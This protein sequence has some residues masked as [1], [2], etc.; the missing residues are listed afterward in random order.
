MT[1]WY[2]RIVL[3]AALVAAVIGTYAVAYRSAMAAYEGRPVSMVQSLQVVVEALTTAGFGGHAPWSSDVVNALVMAMN[4]TGVLLFFLAVPAFVVPLFRNVF[5]ASLPTETDR[6]G[7]V[8]V[9]TCTPRGEALHD[10]L[11]RR[12]RTCVFI[13]PDRET[14]L[15]IQ[16]DGYEVIVGDPELTHVL[17]RANVTEAAGV[18]ADA[19]DDVNAS[20]ALSV[21]ELASDVRVV[22]LIEDADL[23]EYHRLAGADAVLSPRQLI[24]ASLAR[25]VPTL[26]TS[27]AGGASEIEGHVE[28]AELS[29]EP[30]SPLGGRLVR[31]SRL[32]E[33]FGFHAVG[34]WTDG[35]FVSPVG[36]DT[37]LRA[38]MRLL[39]VGPP[40]GVS[41]LRE[42]TASAVR[43]F[44][45]R[46]VVIA[47][48][49]RAGHAAEAAL[50]GSDATLTVLDRDAQEGVDVVG[51]VRDP[52]VLEAAG[53]PEAT[54]ALV[55]V[56]DDTTAIFATLVMR[57]LNPDLY[58]VVRANR[59]EDEPKLLRAG[60]D[61]VQ[62]L[63]SVSGRMVASTLFEDGDDELLG[64]QVQVVQRP[65]GGLQGQTP[66]EA[67]VRSRTGATI[68]AVA[69][70][71]DL[72]A[73]V[74]PHAFTFDAGDEVLIAGTGDSIRQFEETYLA[75]DAGE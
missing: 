53:I 12:G 13:E 47:G 66:A 55:A 51:D 30:G 45:G 43:Q 24:G 41:T 29:V 56:N 60:A 11:E 73:H 59:A 17:E 7:H 71:G 33:D 75:A 39:L 68:L 2:R 72:H 48:Y 34:A 14:A 21:R 40:D 23:A 32:R 38:G 63:A 22:T 3:A 28:F 20:I 31:D 61:L 18:V 10:E 65:V 6:E 1:G 19:A 50:E 37:R 70:G 27:L 54:A 49:G 62:S 58:I 57:R 44:S 4:V 26:A 46:L 67:H 9:C 5:Q 35:T 64:T 36:P 15:A 74:D 16:N 42:K 69:R 25:Q 8:L 52:S